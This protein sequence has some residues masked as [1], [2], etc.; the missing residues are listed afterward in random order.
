MEPLI[1]RGPHRKLSHRATNCV[2]RL[3]AANYYYYYG[4][5]YVDYYKYVQY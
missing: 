2:N 1:L 5:N 4:T 3:R